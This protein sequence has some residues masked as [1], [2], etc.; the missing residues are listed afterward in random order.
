M[1][2]PSKNYERAVQVYEDGGVNAVFEAVDD[3][4]LVADGYHHCEPCELTTPHEGSTCLVCGSQRAQNQ[5][6]DHKIFFKTA[7][8]CYLWL[9]ENEIYN[10]VTLTI[11]LG[12]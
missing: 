10:P 1:Q 5:A 7:S 4:F 11:H 2:V 6:V 8:D 12:D 3:G 9:E